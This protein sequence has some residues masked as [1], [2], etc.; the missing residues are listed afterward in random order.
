MSME[1]LFFF[2]INLFYVQVC[3]L[4]D[5]NRYKRFRF[6]VYYAHLLVSISDVL[7]YMC[8]L[9]NVLCKMLEISFK[10]VE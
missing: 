9:E 3:K 8:N 7:I 6:I 5:S 10:I 2:F 4:I 1:F